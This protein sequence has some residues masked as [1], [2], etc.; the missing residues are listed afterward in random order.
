MKVKTK[1]KKNIEFQ[2]R[3]RLPCKESREDQIQTLD[4]CY[5]ENL[6]DIAYKN[7]ESTEGIGWC[8]FKHKVYMFGGIARYFD[9]NVNTYNEKTNQFTIFK[10]KSKDSQPFGRCF[11]SMTA[12]ANKI[13]IF[14]GEMSNRGFGVRF[15]TNE[16]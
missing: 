16:T 11:H 15:L 4:M 13:L 10:L 14:G 3:Y 8:Y 5:Q 7:F 12:F 9:L 2:E 6:E 1:P